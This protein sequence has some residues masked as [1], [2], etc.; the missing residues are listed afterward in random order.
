MELVE[1]GPLTADD[2]D[3]VL[4]GEVDAFGPVGAGLEWRPKERHVALRDDDG[5]LVALPARSWQRWRSGEVERLPW[6]GWGA[7]WSPG[8]SGGEASCHRSSTR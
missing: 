3:V 1:L 5:R 6:W 7:W 8:R 2:W 4:D